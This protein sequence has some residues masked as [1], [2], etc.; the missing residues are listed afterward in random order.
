MQVLEDASS[1]RSSRATRTKRGSVVFGQVVG[2]H[3]DD[4]ILKDGRVDMMAFKPVARLG[5]S[6]YTTTENVWQHAPAGRSEVSV[7]LV[8]LLRHAPL[9]LGTGDALGEGVMQETTFALTPS[10]NLS[11]KGER[12]MRAES[13]RAHDRRHA[14]RHRQQALV[15]H[16][17]AH[18]HEAD[19][20]LAR[21]RGRAG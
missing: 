13:V 7:T 20:Q 15:G 17:L 14:A 1:C 10:P 19:R 2:V 16:R 5:Y 11:P 8:T 4:S 21:R 9:P 6:E 3:I 18:Q 12:N